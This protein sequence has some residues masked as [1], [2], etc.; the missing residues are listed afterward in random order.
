MGPE[1]QTQTSVR[2]GV[3]RVSK[4]FWRAGSDLGFL[5]R[6]VPGVAGAGARDLAAGMPGF[7]AGPVVP[8]RGPGDPAGLGLLALRSA[9]GLVPPA[10]AGR[11]APA[12]FNRAGEKPRAARGELPVVWDEVVLDVKAGSLSPRRGK[13]LRHR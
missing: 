7:H 13:V 10:G 3:S 2:G 5:L 1:C 6:L 11:A 12:A 4:S 9:S 8:R